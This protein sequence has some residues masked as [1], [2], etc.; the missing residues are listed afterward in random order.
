MG[1]L[2]RP[3]SLRNRRDLAKRQR[4]RLTIGSSYYERKL[5]QIRGTL[6]GFRSEAHVYLTCLV[7]RIHPIP[8]LDS[9]EC[10]T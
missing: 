5:F 7:A 2:R 3:E 4:S 9:G 10:R 8:G 1:D 6:S